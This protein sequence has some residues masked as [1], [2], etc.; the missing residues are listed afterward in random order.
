LTKEIAEIYEA[1]GN[2]EAAIDSFESAA[3]LYSNDNKKSVAQQCMLKVA[4]LAAGMDQ[5][6][7]AAQ[8]FENVGREAMESN[9]SKYS[10]KNYLFQALLCF[11][12]GG[13]SVTAK[14]KKEEYKNVDHTFATQR[15]CT[16]VEKLLVA[17]EVC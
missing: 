12:A 5:F 16:F 8:I 6:P 9:L 15:E 13:D 10:A 2:A 4:T 17:I 3:N 11:L 1:D 14:S 7:R